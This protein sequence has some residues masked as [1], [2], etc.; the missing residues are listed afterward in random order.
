MMR[1]AALLLVAPSVFGFS[2]AILKPSKLVSLRAEG[3]TEAKAQ[4]CGIQF[5][6]G[7]FEPVVP[8]VRLT[9]SRDGTNGVAYFEFER[10]SMFDPKETIEETMQEAITAMR[11]IDEE[12]EISTN[13]IDANFVN[14]QPYGLS[15]QYVMQSMEE[16]DRF[17]RFM[18][19]FAAASE[20]GFADN[21]A[22]EDGGKQAAKS[23][24]V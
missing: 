20:L 12:G 23:Q 16:W 21:S 18:D 11:M 9:R 10:P 14:G 8:N 7:V 13:K 15:V 19:N 5:Y 4:S 17:I 6:P 2:P 22:G 1:L 3:E 24:A